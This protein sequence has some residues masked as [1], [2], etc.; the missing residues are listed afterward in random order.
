[1]FENVKTIV[2]SKIIMIILIETLC[3]CTIA[4]IM[5]IL[6]NTLLLVYAIVNI[7]I[8]MYFDYHDYK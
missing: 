1:M 6:I 8:I 2:I 7:T 4:N 3:I 5:I